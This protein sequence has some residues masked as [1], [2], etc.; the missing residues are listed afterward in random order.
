MSLS[1]EGARLLTRHFY[2]DGRWGWPTPQNRG[3]RGVR[4]DDGWTVVK[5]RPRKPAWAKA[6]GNRL[7]TK[8]HAIRYTLT[9]THTS[10]LQVYLTVWW[11]GAQARSK[12]RRQSHPTVVCAGCHDRLNGRRDVVLT[13][14]DG[15]APS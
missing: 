14:A 7:A 10:G 13:P 8:T 2:G 6:T 15:P 1:L 3:M 9:G 4:G 5:Y 11:C 12:P